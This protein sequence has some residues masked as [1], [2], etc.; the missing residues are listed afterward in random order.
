MPEPTPGAL[1]N[2]PIPLPKDQLL[3]AY[4]TMRTIRDFEE[5]LHVEFAKGDIPGFVHLY[6]GEEACATGVMM[7]LTDIDR[8]ASTHRGHGHCI[9]KGVDVGEMM[10]EIY[11]KE[12]GSCRGKGGS[13][14]IADLS[15]GMMGAN[16]IL[17]AGAPLICG[18][19]LAARFRGDGAVGITFFGDGAANQGT[20][21][22]SMNLA[23]I[24]NLPVIFVIENNGYA[25]ATSVTYATAVNSYV[26]RASGFGLPALSVDGTDF[27]AVY[28]AADELIARARAGGGPALLEC[29]MIRFFG[30]FEGDSQTY[31]AKGE[32]EFNRANRDCL[33]IFADRVT[34]AGVVSEAEIALLDREVAA[35]ID[36]AVAS[37]K[38][39][40]LP[41]AR[42]LL[43]DVYVSY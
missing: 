4:R 20:V 16:G 27:F 2:N 35:L 22:E 36:D 43:S 39:A 23:A 1:S 17:G 29:R 42:D 21:L 30:H 34:A 33:K 6:A 19:G 31:K 5:R 25:E 32:N 40:P 24:W 18:A 41:V 9:A 7:H 38:A 12:T 3:E 28:E 13:M 26:E 11:G 37:A 10:A 15:K 14:H 8:I